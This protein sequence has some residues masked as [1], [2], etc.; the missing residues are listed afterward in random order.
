MTRLVDVRRCNR[1][2]YRSL[3]SLRTSEYDNV[4]LTFT[5]L[6]HQVQPPSK[7]STTHIFSHLLSRKGEPRKSTFFQPDHITRDH[8]AESC[9]TFA[10]YRHTNRISL[11]NSWRPR[12]RQTTTREGR[13][14]SQIWQR[15]S[16]TVSRAGCGGQKVLISLATVRRKK[17]PPTLT[18]FIDT[19]LWYGF[20]PRSDF[21]WITNDLLS[22]IRVFV[23]PIFVPVW[24]PEPEIDHR[25]HVPNLIH[26][27]CDYCFL[28]LILAKL[29]ASPLCPVDHSRA[30]SGTG[31]G[32][33][34]RVIHKIFHRSRVSDPISI[35]WTWNAIGPKQVH[36]D[37]K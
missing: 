15:K 5:D 10:D 11:I 14:V 1:I 33:D 18:L 9:Q 2:V 19:A 36:L 32:N 37:P 26:F 7:S 35:L 30:N 17:N 23:C 6:S 3:G 16:T 21:S 4:S 34:Q 12:R 28:L 25:V 22:G 27:D 24:L 8:P 31:S 29:G 20:S 13:P